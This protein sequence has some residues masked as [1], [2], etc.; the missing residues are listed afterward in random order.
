V[1]LFGPAAAALV[2]AAS[3]GA[4]ALWRGL[5]V[6]MARRLDTEGAV[7]R[8]FSFASF[9]VLAGLLARLLIL[10]AGE[11]ATVGLEV[12]LGAAVIGV[13]A[14][15]LSRRNLLVGVASG[16]ISFALAAGALG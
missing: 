12:R 14:F 2:L 6:I 8:W 7:F 9:A 13:A 3:V 4:T 11:L 16:T 15:Y 1:S 5:G 10:P